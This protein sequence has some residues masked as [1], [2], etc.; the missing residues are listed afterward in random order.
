MEGDQGSPGDPGPP[1]K[2][3]IS[4]TPSSLFSPSLPLSL[5]LFLSLSLLFSL[6]FSHPLHI[7]LHCLHN[8]SLCL[9][10]FNLLGP[11]RTCWSHWTNWWPW[12]Y[13]WIWFTWHPRIPR[14]QRRRCEYTCIQCSL[15]C[16]YLVVSLMTFDYMI[17]FLF[18]FW[19]YGQECLIL[20]IILE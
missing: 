15:V 4:T 16:C 12:D 1:G 7:S 10:P 19:F 18:F 20:L 8:V 17:V 13:W 5:S 3:V 9:S 2:T 6:S 14:T 11:C